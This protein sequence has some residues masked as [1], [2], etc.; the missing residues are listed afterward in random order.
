MLGK[1]LAA[2]ACG[3]AMIRCSLAYIAAVWFLGDPE[4]GPAVTAVTGQLLFAACL[5]AWG[6]LASCLVSHQVVAYFLA[7]M[8]SLLLFLV[9]ALGRFLPPA[10]PRSPTSCPC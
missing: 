10:W 5:V 7:F 4:A 2:A 9:G 6:L 3:A 1:W 8:M